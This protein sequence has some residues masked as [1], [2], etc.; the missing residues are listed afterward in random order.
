ME[1]RTPEE[2]ERTD[3]LTELEQRIREATARTFER[4]RMPFEGHLDD[5]NFTDDLGRSIT[6]R[7]WENGPRIVVC[8]YD[9]GRDSV[10]E[11]MGGPEV[12]R[13]VAT[14][15][16]IPGESGFQ[17]RVEDLYVGA[18]GYRNAGIERQL[19]A[20]VEEFAQ[21][22]GAETLYGTGFRGEDRLAW[23]RQGRDGWQLNDDGEHLQ[24][25]KSLRS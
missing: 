10:P 19:L 25:Y 12:G 20:Q 11:K 9:I 21:R 24:A 17:V 23:S 13:A 15:E 3:G 2:F 14:L 1:K 5:R 4:G 7:S 18:E 16:R 22:Q 6:A 8:A